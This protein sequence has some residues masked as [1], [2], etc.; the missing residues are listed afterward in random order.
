MKIGINLATRPLRRDRPILVA[1]AA[2]GV[3]LLAALGLLVSIAVNERRETSETRASLARVNRQLGATRTEE[4]RLEASMHQPGN[5]VALDRSI[6][7]NTLIKRKAISWTRIFAD[8]E[9]VLPP[10]VR[11]LAVR[12]QVN[13][14]DQVSLDLSSVA[15]DSPE[16]VID[17]LRH[18]K[19]GSAPTFS[20]PLRRAATRRQRQTDPFFSASVSPDGELCPE[21]LSP[22][23]PHVPEIP[24]QA[25]GHQEPKVCACGPLGGAASIGQPR[26]RRSVAF[27]LFGASP[28]TLNQRTS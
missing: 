22:P 9:T 21:T 7:I 6:L 16:P 19:R 18:A 15:A 28:E 13:A 12:P 24:G 3:L 11:L 14:Q 20:V 2:V 26:R 4:S 25:L 23:L 1:S 27:H 5:A 10:N 8:L 17:R